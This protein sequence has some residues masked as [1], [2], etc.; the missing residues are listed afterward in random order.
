VARIKKTVFTFCAI[1]LL[2]LLGDIYFGIDG[3]A[4]RWEDP[5]LSPPPPHN[6]KCSALTEERERLT[7]PQAQFRAELE[8]KEGTETPPP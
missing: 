8:N 2:L 4:R 7:L 6:V 1:A 5:L 3:M